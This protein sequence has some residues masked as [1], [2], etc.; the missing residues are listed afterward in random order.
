MLDPVYC[1]QD[2]AAACDVVRG[3]RMIRE[4]IAEIDPAEQGDALGR[5]RAAIAHKTSQAV[6]FDSRAW[7]VTAHRR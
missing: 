2:A 4:A 7:L 6:P 5:L 3:F 1:G